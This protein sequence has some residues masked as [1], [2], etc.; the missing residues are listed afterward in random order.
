MNE[1][2]NKIKKSD[3]KSLFL[4]NNLYNFGFNKN[5]LNEM[6]NEL[7]MK[8]EVLHIK[9]D[10]YVLGRTLRKELFSKQILSNMLLNDS[11][12]SMEYILSRISWIPENVYV[13]TC[14][15]NRK[16]M[17]INTK[18]G[19]FGYFNIT[20]NNYLAGV[21]KI[22]ENEFVF[23]R[24]KPLKAL[25]DMIC[26]R[27]YEWTSLYPLHNS[28]RIEYEDLET[29]TKNDFDELQGVY[30]NINVEKFLNGI[31]KELTL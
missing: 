16:S 8:N 30:K 19:N 6:L 4:T 20:Q 23:Y 15:T 7:V 31:R 18:Y 12:V 11:Y 10:I 1:L 25:A 9:N 29:L 24:A 13:I 22:I 26:N 5:Y 17:K 14:V 21:E 2:Y 27:K 3:I 28:L